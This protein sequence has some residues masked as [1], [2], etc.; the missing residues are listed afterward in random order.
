MSIFITKCVLVV[1]IVSLK[2][3]QKSEK[4]KT[5]ISIDFVRVRSCMRYIKT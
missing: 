3:I 4:V 5:D 1:N 2:I